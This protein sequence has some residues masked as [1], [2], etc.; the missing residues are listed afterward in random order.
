MSGETGRPI[1]IT[2][3]AA[4][5]HAETMRVR[6]R[7]RCDDGRTWATALG[8]DEQFGRPRPRLFGMLHRI[9]ARLADDPRQ[10]A[11]LL[12]P[13]AEDVR[14]VA[15]CSSKGEADGALVVV[16]LDNRLRLVSRHEQ[17]ADIRIRSRG[18]DAVIE[19]LTNLA[20]EANELVETYLRKTASD[21]GVDRQLVIYGLTERRLRG[22]ET[23]L[24]LPA[25][26]LGQYKEWAATDGVCIGPEHD[27]D[28]AICYARKLGLR[29]A[30]TCEIRH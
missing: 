16:F 27:L 4:T 6:L 26:H 19:A 21:N 28:A 30:E 9:L 23:A 2:G 24:G 17:F 20:D 12:H 25:H 8:I 11:W 7:R 29:Y 1:I 22:L 18:I 15:T 3:P 14:F 5:F 10:T 13:P